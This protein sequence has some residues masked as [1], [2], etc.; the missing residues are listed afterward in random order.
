MHDRRPLSIPSVA[1]L[2]ADSKARSEADI[3]SIIQTV[4]RGVPD[5][6]AIAVAECDGTIGDLV[7]I[8]K[9]PGFTIH[10]YWP[11]EGSKAMMLIIKDCYS[12]LVKQLYWHGRSFSIA[13]R[14][15]DFD[16]N[17]FDIESEMSQFFIFLHAR[18][19][20]PELDLPS[21]ST[22][23]ETEEF[24]RYY[25]GRFQYQYYVYVCTEFRKQITLYSCGKRLSGYLPSFQEY[26]LSQY[27]IP[28][29]GGFADL[30]RVLGLKSLSIPAYRNYRFLFS[31]LYDPSYYTD[32][33]RKSARGP[34]M[35]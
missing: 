14:S 1:F 17:G 15:A 8:P 16:G 7:D 30:G 26:S 4:G 24:L 5:W 28:W 9:L 23:Q 33:K 35:H 13:F 25:F 32:S 18:P 31:L 29:L 34:Y 6:G 12:H 3:I 20:S 19:Q 21:L 11:G 27:N 22:F 2:N 10:R